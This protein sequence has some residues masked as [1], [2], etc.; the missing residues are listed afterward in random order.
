MGRSKRSWDCLSAGA[1]GGGGGRGRAA[2]RALGAG[3]PIAQQPEGVV[4]GVVAVGPGGREGVL[5]DE[6]DVGQGRLLGGEGRG[7]VE[8]TR[9][10]RLATAERAGAEPAQWA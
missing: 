4:A 3:A 5:A 6:G 2:G 1:C 10:P 9:Q 7:G 8:P